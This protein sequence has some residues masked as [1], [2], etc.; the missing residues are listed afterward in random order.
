MAKTKMGTLDWIAIVLLLVGGL[1]WGFVGLF[2]F[3]LV[4]AVFGASAFLTKLVY[5]L[6]GASAVYSIYTLFVKK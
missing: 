3:N 1:N 4:T 2:E 5:V 6:V